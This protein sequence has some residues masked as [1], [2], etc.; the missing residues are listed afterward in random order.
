MRIVAL[1]R[2]HEIQMDC[3]VTKFE[4]IYS[5]KC[6]FSVEVYCLSDGINV[7]DVRSFLKRSSRRGGECSWNPLWYIAYL[8]ID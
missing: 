2:L 8:K 1:D 3:N 4:N 7:N 5:M 6:S